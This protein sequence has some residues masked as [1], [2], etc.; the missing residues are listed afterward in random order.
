MTSKE[1]IEKRNRIMQEAGTLAQGKN[2]NA[3]TRAKV[4]TMLAEAD[5][6]AEDLSTAQALE[7]HANEMRSA[8]RPPRGE[9][10]ATNESEQEQRAFRDWMRT[11]T[12][13]SE[14]RS[15]LRENRDMGSFVGVGQSTNTITSSVLVPTGMDG[16]LSISQK[17]YGALV[18]AVRNFKTA[19]GEPIRYVMADDVENS[20]TLLPTEI[21]PV[22]ELDPNLTGGIS[23][24]DDLTTGVVKVSNNL[25]NDS[26]FSVSDF[27]SEIFG[28]RYFRGLS[29]MI[30]QGNGSHIVS[31]GSNVP[32][33][34]TTASPE[35]YIT[36]SDILGLYGSLDPVFLSNA[37]WL[38]SPAVR[39]SLMGL[40]NSFGTPLLQPSI[41]GEPFS[42]IYGRPIITTP[43][44]PAV[45]AGST[46]VLFG[47]LSSYTLRTVT[48][49]LL[50][51]RL[52]ELFSLTAETGFVGRTRAGSYSTLQASSPA[53]VAMKIHA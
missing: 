7:A 28:K 13:S 5:V 46:P 35:G 22:T 32:V 2:V 16:L 18:G 20:L 41:S 40:V 49:G 37:S 26:A 50:I 23:Y 12:I 14:N 1:I 19:T 9:I 25:L 17:N 39:S 48:D 6:L 42:T 31:I 15:Y 53:I 33:T 36:L 47:D 30:S 51:V 43:F 4:K 45:A 21:T 29:Q 24:V 3:E 52:N 44:Q 27:I 8:S 11:G 38:M 10:G 34:W